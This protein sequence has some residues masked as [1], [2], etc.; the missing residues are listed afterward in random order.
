ME[1]KTLKEALIDAWDALIPLVGLNLLWVVL[2]LLVVT[3]FPAYAGLHFA[4]NQIAHGQ[5]AGIRDFFEGFKKYFW[6]SWK[7]GLINLVLYFL[8]AV[9]LRFY[10]GFEGFGFVLLQGFF[11]AFT[12]LWT[13]VQMYVFPFILEQEEPSIKMAFRNSAVICLQ[14]I[15][16]TIGL[17]V[18]FFIFCVISTLL[19]PIWILLTVSFMTYMANWQ[20]ITAIR[21]L[22]KKAEMTDIQAS[23]E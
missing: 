13:V 8:V 11:V 1:S 2:T 19:P 18:F 17:F 7:Y 22:R 20:T 23:T 12:V 5:S 4:T 15:K 9:N 16:S 3:A 10:G 14:Y 6:I 21:K